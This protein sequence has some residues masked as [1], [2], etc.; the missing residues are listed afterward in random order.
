MRSSFPVIVSLGRGVFP[1]L[2]VRA[3]GPAPGRATHH[4]MSPPMHFYAGPSGGDIEAETH[5]G[6]RR[7]S[8]QRIGGHVEVTGKRRFWVD[9]PSAAFSVMSSA[10]GR[11]R[12]GKISSRSSCMMVYPPR[13]GERKLDAVGSSHAARRA[14]GGFE[15]QTEQP[16][17]LLDAD[18]HVGRT[19]FPQPRRAIAIVTL[20][21]G[22]QLPTM[23][24]TRESPSSA[25]QPLAIDRYLARRDIR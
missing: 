5:P 7:L 14:A 2:A 21:L 10:D 4:A 9:R 12:M 18:H 6:G 23:F 8:F 24:N 1:D 17:R 20:A 19:Q 3:G 16:L 11:S 15:D 25:A 22:A 13:S